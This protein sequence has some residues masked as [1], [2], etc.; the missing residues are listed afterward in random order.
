[1]N[2]MDLNIERKDSGVGVVELDG[3]VGKSWTAFACPLHPSPSP[4]YAWA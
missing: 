3:D 2:L 4:R 1:M